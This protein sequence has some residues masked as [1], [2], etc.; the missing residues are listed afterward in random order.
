MSNFEQMFDLVAGHE[1]G[2]TD[3]PADAGNWTGGEIGEGLCRETKLGVRR[4]GTPGPGYRRSD[5]H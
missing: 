3:D 4:C 1:G 5:T 2:F